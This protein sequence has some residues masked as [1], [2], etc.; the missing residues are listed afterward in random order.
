LTTNYTRELDLSWNQ[1]AKY[2]AIT[3]GRALRTNKSLKILNLSMNRFCDEGGHEVAN[4]LMQN[5]T[6]QHLDMA[7]NN[8]TGHAAVTFS[9][10]IRHNRTLKY[11]DITNNNVGCTGA[12]V[13]LRSVAM[14]IFCDVNISFHDIEVLNCVKLHRFYIYS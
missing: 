8:M 12:K 1:I 11:L 5:S 4:A 13:L 14:G 10:A 7:R 9:Y 6:L 2:G 3:I